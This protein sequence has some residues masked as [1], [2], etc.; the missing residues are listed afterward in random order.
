M[1]GKSQKGVNTVYVPLRT[2][3]PYRCRPI[4][5]MA[6]ALLWLST[7]HSWT[8][9]VTPFWHSADYVITSMCL[10]PYTNIP[11]AMPN[12]NRMTPPLLLRHFSRIEFKWTKSSVCVGGGG[13]ISKSM[14]LIFRRNNFLRKSGNHWWAAYKYWNPMTETDYIDL[15]FCC[16][17]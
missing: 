3:R 16:D 13:D 10:A 1:S 9:V 11:G 5:S 2:R 7:E 14:S 4:K 12:Q 6:I 8:A 17:V 15:E